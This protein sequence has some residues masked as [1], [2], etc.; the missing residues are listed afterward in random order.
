VN[1]SLDT[2]SCKWNCSLDTS[3]CK[4]TVPWTQAAA[5]G[6]PEQVLR[7]FIYAG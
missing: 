1:C 4:W 6:P 3:S 2:S 5:L 7:N